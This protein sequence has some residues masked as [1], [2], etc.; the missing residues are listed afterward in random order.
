MFK[1]PY[2]FKLK[3][4]EYIIVG[5][6][7]YKQAAKEFNIHQEQIR[8]WT[9]RY[10]AWGKDGLKNQLPK[11][12]DGKFKLNVVEY[13]Y[14][15]HLSLE[16]T[17]IHFKLPSSTIVKLWKQMYDEKGAKYL[18]KNRS[19]AIQSMRVKWMKNKNVPMDKDREEEYLQKIET[20]QMEN[21]YLKKLHA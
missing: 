18:L 7:S 6:H 8:I 21:D 20:L 9:N 12:Y 3:A 16:K 13:M 15:N 2:D 11:K 10:K 14:A 5:K 1:Y 17:A 4:V 19:L